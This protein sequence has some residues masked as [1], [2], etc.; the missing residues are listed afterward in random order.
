[1]G[2]DTS[3]DDYALKPITQ[4]ITPYIDMFTAFMQ[5]YTPLLRLGQVPL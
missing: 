4:V 5:H 1:M 2:S 3:H